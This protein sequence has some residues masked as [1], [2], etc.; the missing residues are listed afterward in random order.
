MPRTAYWTASA[1]SSWDIGD[2]AG[3]NG[4]HVFAVDSELVWVK[5]KARS[6][7]AQSAFSRSVAAGGSTR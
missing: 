2:L 7:I 5:L 4:K 3:G 1:G 6:S